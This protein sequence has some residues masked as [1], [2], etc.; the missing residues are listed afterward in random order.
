MAKSSLRAINKGTRYDI[1]GKMRNLIR[2]IESGEI[3]P[4]D[5]LVVTS[6]P[7]GPNRSNK[8]ILHHM[9]FGSTEEIHWMLST[10]KG[11]IEPQ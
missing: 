11:R 7:T 4:R 8:I 1:T 6:E 5:I 2:R 10:A 9:G 3:A